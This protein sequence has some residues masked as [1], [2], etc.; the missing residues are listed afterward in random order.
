MP[1]PAMSVPDAY[2]RICAPGAPFEWEITDIRGVPT[3]AYKNAPPS[4]APIFALSR[5]WGD[6]P[7]LVLEDERVSFRAHANAVAR[8]AHVLRD[9]MGVKP[10]DRV[11]IVMRNLPEWPVAFFAATLIGAIASPLNAWWTGPELE[12]GL[13]DSGAR[14]LIADAERLARLSEHL[15]ACKDLAHVVVARAGDDLA[16]TVRR[17]ED[18]VG[19]PKSWADLPH[20]DL[21]D[22]ALQPDDPCTLLYT[23]GTTGAPKGALGT[24]RNIATNLFNLMAAQARMFLRRGEAP[25]QPNPAEPR[26]ATLIS[27]P[28]FHATGCFAVLIPALAAGTKIVMMRRWDAGEGLRLIEA[29]KINSFGGVPAIA[30]QVIEH[31]DFAKYDT[32][33]VDMVSY[34]GAPSSSELV[35][36][37]V[38]AFPNVTPGQ[39]YGLTETAAAVTSNGGEDYKLRPTSCGPAAPVNELR[40]VDPD[41]KDVPAG[42]VG[43]LWI[44]GP[45]TVV[46]YWNKPEAT[47][48]AFENGWFKSGDLVRMDEDGFVFIVDRAKD[49]I[50]RGG[51]TVYCVEVEDALYQH[52]A[53][54]DAA[55][56]GIPHKVLGEEVGAI[57]TVK[58]GSDV[59]EEELRRWVAARLAGFKVPVRI[60]IR[61]EPL[62]R[63]AN[64]K[65]LKRDL[66]EAFAPAA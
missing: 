16:P 7:Y 11:A 8:F 37:V 33:S 51:E 6:L 25:P 64:G 52:D 23:S 31:P 30:W 26:K 2:A 27:I 44:K 28:F 24:H 4:L 29:E 9:E 61:S 63:N 35:A 59:S 20:T 40:V 3:R 66:R 57:V 12:Y 19:A 14:V 41:G 43:E 48:A 54:T 45:N 60:Q 36:A 47:E 32:S 53:V 22:V 65:I 58:P 49:M 42:E 18:L 62:P 17:M 15:P 13:V 38:R 46:G 50:N 55:V 56:V 39:G 10:G 1:F 34:G 5:M 21:P